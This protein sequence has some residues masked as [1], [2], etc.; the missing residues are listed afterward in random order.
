[1]KLLQ[2]LSEKLSRRAKA[3]LA[4]SLAAV[5]AVTI[6]AVFSADSVDED[7][8]PTLLFRCMD[9]KLVQDGSIQALVRISA[10]NM[11]TFTGT[12]FNIEFNPYYI[13]PSYLVDADS[14][15]VEDAQK[16]V[17]DSTKSDGKHFTVDPALENIKKGTNSYAYPFVE[18]APEGYQLNEVTPGKLKSD[19]TVDENGKLQMYLKLDN[20]LRSSY[21]SNRYKDADGNYTYDAIQTVSRT[22][23]LKPWE[24][25]YTAGY[26]IIDA[27]G[28]V[29]RTTNEASG[30]VAGKDTYTEYKEG[31]HFLG[32]GTPGNGMNLGSLTFWVDP[33]HLTEMVTSF[34]ESTDFLIGYPG[35]VEGKD[36]WMITDLAQSPYRP[37]DYLANERKPKGQGKPGQGPWGDNGDEEDKQNYARVVFDFIFPRV[38]V[39]AAVA[40]GSDL[41]VNAYQAYGDGTLQDIAD[42]LQRYRPE[43]TTTTA[44]AVETDYVIKWGDTTPAPKQAPFDSRGGGYKV[45]RPY[46]PVKDAALPA[47][48]IHK[49]RRIDEDAMTAA[50]QKQHWWVEL[51]NSEYKNEKMY[52]GDK[53][54]L[55]TQYFYYEEDGE[56]KQFPQPMEVYLNVTPVALV[57]VVADRLSETYT[58]DAAVSFETTNLTAFN[59]PNQAVLSLSPVPGPIT[60]TMPIAD[61]DWT[62]KT[63]GNLTT[64]NGQEQNWRPA[65]AAEGTPVTPGDYKVAGPKKDDII[66]YVEKTSPWVTTTGFDKDIVATRTVLKEDETAPGRN[67]AKYKAAYDSTDNNG[68]LTLKVNKTDT[69][70]IAAGFVND[71]TNKLP[72]FRTYLPSGVLIDIQDDTK[73]LPPSGGATM[74]ANGAVSTASLPNASADNPAGSSA[75][76]TYYPGTNTSANPRSDHQE[77]VSRAINLGGWFHVSVCEELDNNGN[78]LW[79]ELLPVYVPPR[80]NYYG[81]A[82]GRDYY[83]YS[84]D[85]DQRLYFFDFSGTRAGLYPFY[86]D[87]ELPTHVV[88]PTGYTVTTTYDGLTGAEPGALGQFEVKKWA[89]AEEVPE[90]PVPTPVAAT[91]PPWKGGSVINYGAPAVPAQP[92]AS[93][94]VAAQPADPKKPTDFKDTVYP[95]FGAVENHTIVSPLAVVDHGAKGLEQV[96]MRVQAAPD[97]T[98]APTPKPSPE[99]DP[100]DPTPTP[101]PATQPVESI[102]LIHE[103]RFT[104]DNAS[105][106]T[107]Q[108]GEVSKVTYT[109]QTEGYIAR[110]TYTL[111]LENNGETDIYGLSIDVV[112]GTHT[113]AYEPGKHDVINHFEILSQPAAYLPAGG[114]TTF[115]ITYVYNLFDTD[116][117]KKET[118]YEDEILILSN[119]HHDTSDPL[120]KFTA[121]FAVT[122]DATYKVTVISRPVPD[123]DG[124]GTN[125]NPDMGKGIIVVGPKNVPSDTAVQSAV[126]AVPTADKEKTPAVVNVTGANAKVDETEAANTY[127]AEHKY[128]WI[129]AE[130]NDEYAVK[131]VYYLDGYKDDQETEKRVLLYVNDWRDTGTDA[132]DPADARDYFFQMPSRNV[133]VVVE[134]YEPIRSK[135]R[136]SRLMGYAGQT[137]DLSG[138][139][140]EGMETLPGETLIDITPKQAE[141]DNSLTATE[142]TKRHNIRWYENTFEIIQDDPA[143]KD[144]PD[145]DGIYNMTPEDSSKEGPPKLAYLMVLGDY[146]EEQD[147]QPGA[148]G[149]GWVQLR[150]RLRT[151]TLDPDI[152]PISVE[153]HEYDLTP[154]VVNRRGGLLSVDASPP[155]LPNGYTYHATTGAPTTHDSYVFTAPPAIGEDGLPTYRAVEIV[156]KINQIT[157][158]MVDA[159]PS[160]TLDE[161]LERS[162]V[163]VIARAGTGVSSQLNYGNSP[164]G[165]IYNNTTLNDA[166]KAEAWKAFVANNYAFNDASR[167]SKAAGL[168]NT[169]WKEA[170]GG[171]TQNMAGK[172]NSL[173]YNG[174]EDP[175]SLFIILGQKFQDPGF[176]SLKNTAG[177]DVDPKYIKRSVT[178]DQLDTTDA[179]TTQALRFNALRKDDSTLDQVTL[180]LGAGDKGL[181]TSTATDVIDKWWQITTKNESDGTEKTTDYSVRP[182]LY[183]LEYTFP[184][185][186]GE[187]MLTVTRP[188]IILAPVGDVNA[189]SYVINGKETGEN[190][191][192]SPSDAEYVKNRI[193]DPLGGMMTP[194]ANDSAAA[195]D[196][197]CWRLFRYRC[198]DSNNDRNINNID[199][200]Q[201]LKDKTKLVPY[202]KPTDYISK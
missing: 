146:T 104:S 72:R 162:F 118:T 202:Y 101:E 47:S 191:K 49:D 96:R 42:T 28:T 122:G 18:K 92:S 46:D 31:T 170:W 55:C 181:V 124:D 54:Y 171:L 142:I 200:N 168:N 86:T 41:T 151:N 154:G 127:V 111:T 188:L 36:S 185:Y 91:A 135:L 45:Y 197:P 172:G 93:P 1:M 140:A 126:D 44:D 51:S 61:E 21:K 78:E 149:L 32:K 22:N 129:H 107:Y 83:T 17:D 120:K 193:K 9:F 99:P 14:D 114:K 144:T 134:F 157:Q 113:P 196:Y 65:G 164:A 158:A 128:V 69:N 179:A 97:I 156:L 38:V 68:K 187:T 139:P 150:A 145:K 153:F 199:A 155:S 37:T 85:P 82:T 167:P 79:S 90:S 133:T 176:K 175:Y 201:I 40:G 12:G 52:K 123:A 141:L 173:S 73:G 33:D 180:N 169:Y 194:N 34:N 7:K 58:Q 4:V 125:E 62:P 184:D 130:P 64:A 143:Y 121:N 53:K 84:I 103:S 26:V 159:D 137:T 189:D 67:S 192:N 87:S 190:V 25:G 70:D 19:G 178:V 160:L 8:R 6:W 198:C 182:A 27:S 30:M 195:P 74:P 50:E 148:D 94:P 75:T 43:I 48:S 108:S 136:L 95:A 76:L 2:R 105:G 15:G 11:P 115:V 59:L 138:E 98:P 13:Q 77:D 81:P 161:E 117:T 100:P 71:S 20:T 60:L 35:G 23:L 165:M 119:G 102:R 116:P 166:E 132:D 57:D 183:T 80:T 39:K 147:G 89:A 10:E 24:N 106:I 5:T 66:K 177:L 16:R 3:A 63:I 174:D 152:D 109:M 88:L 112:N 29:A 56:V 186:D 110:E 163:V 131:S